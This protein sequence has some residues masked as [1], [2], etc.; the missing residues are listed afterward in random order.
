MVDPLSGLEVPADANVGDILIY[1]LFPMELKVIDVKPCVTDDSVRSAPHKQY[2]VIDPDGVPDWVCGWD[3]Y[4]PE[5]SLDW[6]G[7]TR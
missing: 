1:A 3:L 7:W 4:K 5:Q 6:S 2:Q